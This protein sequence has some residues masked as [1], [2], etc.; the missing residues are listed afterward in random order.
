MDGSKRRVAIVFAAVR[1]A[2][3]ERADILIQESIG[4][5]GGF[6]NEICKQQFVWE[7]GDFIVSDRPAIGMDLDKRSLGQYSP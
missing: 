4:T 6:L 5:E 1:E 2:V 3:G 7:K